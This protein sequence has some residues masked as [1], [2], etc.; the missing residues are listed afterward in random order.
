M[1][2][3]EKSETFHAKA[4]N[5]AAT[6]IHQLLQ[7]IPE[8][9]SVIVVFDWKEPLD[10]V[11]PCGVW[12]DRDGFVQ[13]QSVGSISGG[14]C[15]LSKMFRVQQL[16]ALQQIAG[17][18]AAVEQNQRLLKQSQEKLDAQKEAFDQIARQS[19]ADLVPDQG[20]PDGQLP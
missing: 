2:E 8:L 9:R 17:I 12:Q 16:L 1:A 19:P 6:Q 7:E 14:M 15:Q 4:V 10:E 20:R 3:K 13:P 11:T 5:Q 18:R